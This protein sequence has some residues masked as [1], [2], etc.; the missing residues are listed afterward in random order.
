VTDLESVDQAARRNQVS[1]GG[2]DKRRMVATDVVAVSTPA[3]PTRPNRRK[4]IV[5]PSKHRAA[6]AALS[7]NARRSTPSPS[8]RTRRVGV[9]GQPWAE[10]GTRRRSARAA[11]KSA[12]ELLHDRAALTVL[13][14][15][16]AAKRSTSSSTRCGR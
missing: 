15:A 14:A 5:A 10:P 9:Q 13:L 1:G 2:D 16:R 3:S 8:S 4:T 12:Y 6:T 11:C 7:P